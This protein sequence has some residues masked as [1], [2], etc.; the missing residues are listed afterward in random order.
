MIFDFSQKLDTFCLNTGIDMTPYNL[1]SNFYGQLY[2]NQFTG[3]GC[4][5]G[6][7]NRIVY[8]LANLLRQWMTFGSRLA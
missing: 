2:E 3:G 6:R 7:K 5:P 1:E 4:V 8:R